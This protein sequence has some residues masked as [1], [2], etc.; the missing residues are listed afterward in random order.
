[1]KNHL[2]GLAKETTGLAA[3]S[4]FEALLNEAG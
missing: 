3:S 1:M 4:A 2:R